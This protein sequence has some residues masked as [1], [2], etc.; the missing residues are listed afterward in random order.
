[1]FVRLNTF[2]V[3]GLLHISALGDDEY[4]FQPERMRI[5]GT[6]SN[7]S[8]G[9]GEKV[10]V[11]VANVNTERRHIDLHLAPVKTERKKESIKRVRR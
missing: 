6:R 11:T 3:D 1:M 10:R 7:A 2:H 8:Y 4:E 9:I 5:I